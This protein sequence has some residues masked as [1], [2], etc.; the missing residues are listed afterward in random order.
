MEQLN[1]LI[2]SIRRELRFDVDTSSGQVIIRVID[3][4]TQALVRQIPSD[5]VL[6]LMEHMENASKGVLM[7]TTA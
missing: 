3:A 2:Q 6:T 1:T 7:N 4:K 5:E